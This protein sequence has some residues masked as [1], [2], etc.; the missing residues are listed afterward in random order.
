MIV[1]AA[2]P[3]CGKTSMA[4]QI[5]EHVGA[6]YENVLVASLEMDDSELVKR[7]IAAHSGIESRRITSELPD[8]EKEKIKQTI[9]KVAGSNMTFYVP[10]F[11][12]PKMIRSAAKLTQSKSGLSLIVVD[13][14]GLLR[15]E[16]RQEIYQRVTENSQQL[17]AIGREMKVPILVLSQLNRDAEGQIPTLK[18][19]RDSGAIEQD[20]DRVIFLSPK[21]VSYT[22]LTLPTKA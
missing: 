16:K 22:H 11:A 8:G 13:Y 9:G 5:A 14:I 19:L 1:L 17:K 12:T 15:G 6:R 3:G 21:A 4:L 20:A 2:R 10:P 18:H 7:S